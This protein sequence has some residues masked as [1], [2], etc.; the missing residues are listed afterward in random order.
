MG[1]LGGGSGRYF[2]ATPLSVVSLI[3]P[4]ELKPRLGTLSLGFMLLPHHFFP[5]DDFFCP[6]VTPSCM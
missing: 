6:K 2:I 3:Q 1:D 5:T 4:N